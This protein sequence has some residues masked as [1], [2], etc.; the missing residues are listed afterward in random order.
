MRIFSFVLLVSY[1]G[2]LFVNC[3]EN[4]SQP[5]CKRMRIASAPGPLSTVPEDV[6]PNAPVSYPP[7]ISKPS[8]TL[9]S[10]GNSKRIKYKC[11]CGASD[12]ISCVINQLKSGV[13][14]SFP[15]PKCGVK[16]LLPDILRNFM[17]MTRETV[18]TA[19]R[20]DYLESNASTCVLWYLATLD[21]NLIDATISSDQ[22]VT[23]LKLEWAGETFSIDLDN[24]EYLA[25]SGLDVKQNFAIICAMNGRINILKSLISLG[26]DPNALTKKKS[27]ALHTAI[28]F[29]HPDVLKY[30]L[31]NGARTDIKSAN[32]G[33]P[34]HFALEMNNLVAL[35]LLLN[36]GADIES[37]DKDGKTIQTKAHETNNLAALAIIKRYN[38][39]PSEPIPMEYFSLLKIIKNIIETDDAKEFESIL[40]LQQNIID[41]KDD[42]GHYLIVDAAQKSTQVF[43]IFVR[44]LKKSRNQFI[45]FIASFY[46]ALKAG[47]MDNIQVLKS[48]GYH[49]NLRGPASKFTGELTV[50]NYAIQ[51][52]DAQ[53]V[54]KLLQM[55]ANPRLAQPFRNN[56]KAIPPLMDAV[57]V[58]NPKIVRL[59]LNYGASQDYSDN[60]FLIKLLELAILK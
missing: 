39:N 6:T 7:V 10:N 55:G 5:A 12:H 49:E 52:N 40:E 54:E 56:V 17:K 20:L 42:D 57:T 51:Q 46:F 43:Q 25:G 58:N 4:T 8:C 30:L 21:V 27:T 50:L 18:P 31:E 29:D 24:Q 53:I 11:S 45:N 23:T 60:V 44:E 1:F 2:S 48:H 33:L 22:R 26:I 3:G 9:C 38:F 41:L 35:I 37:I 47:R 59:L 14:F 16:Q 13:S 36:A 32:Y 28:K 15:C 34:T 19:D